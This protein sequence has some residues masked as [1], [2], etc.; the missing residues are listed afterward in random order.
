M[1]LTSIY[2]TSFT[3]LPVWLTCDKLS[4]TSTPKSHSK[5]DSFF[6]PR[7]MIDLVWPHFLVPQFSQKNLVK[8]NFIIN[9]VF[10]QCQGHSRSLLRL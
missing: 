3:T 6:V 8:L 1:T 10:D 7:E 5:T 9:N 4:S 2:F